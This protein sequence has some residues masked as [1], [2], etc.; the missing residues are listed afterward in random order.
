MSDGDL[1]DA[2]AD[3]RPEALVMAYRRHSSSTRTVARRVLVDAG[4]AEDVVQ[5]V[6]VQ[7]WCHPRRYDP[8]RGALRGWL[9]GQARSRSVDIVRCEVA[10]RLREERQARGGDLHVIPGPEPR[11][12]EE[13]LAAHVVTV[14]EGLPPHE[15]EAVHLAYFCGHSYRQVAALLQEP[16]GTV[17]AR[18]RAGMRRLHA[19]LYADGTAAAWAFPS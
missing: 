15:R 5:D 10:R 3:A 19:L 2:I 14:V 9:H 13:A 7:L 4:A 11:V 18:I 1:V 8:G 6:F 17:K 16:E 12:V